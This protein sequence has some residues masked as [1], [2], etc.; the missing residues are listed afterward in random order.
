ME[1]SHQKLPME[2][3][4]F[5]VTHGVGI[6]D[7]TQP[8]V[9]YWNGKRAFDEYW[10]FMRAPFWFLT[11]LLTLYAAVM[12]GS[13]FFC[14]APFAFVVLGLAAVLAFGMGCGGY[15][16]YIRRLVLKVREP[17]LKLTSEGLSYQLLHTKIQLIPWSNVGKVEVTKR[18]GNRYLFIFLTDLSDIEADSRTMSNI[19]TN[20][21]LGHIRKFMKMPMYPHLI[22]TEAS[23]PIDADQLSEAID[24]R[25]KRLLCG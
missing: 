24:Q 14:G 5:D 18:F 6:D 7:P 9:L 1:P 15:V 3:M 16:L 19:R 4:E 23:L 22:I 8:L 20:H 2:A 10:R 21:F 25:R 12:I 13:Y 17:Q 11:V